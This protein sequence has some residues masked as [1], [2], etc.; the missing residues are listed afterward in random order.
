MNRHVRVALATLGVAAVAAIPQAHPAAAQ[1]GDPIAGAVE[2]FATTS[3]YPGVAVVVTDDDGTTH[4]TDYGVDADG[5]AISPTTPMPI[6]SA[7][8]TITAAAVM[9]LVAAGSVDLDSPVYDYLPDF[10]IHDPR[11]AEIT[12]RHLLEQTSGI[13][14]LTLREKSLAQPATLAEAEQR[15]RDA[16]LATDPG[17]KYAYT[18]TNFHLAAR[19]VEVVTG[20]PFGD[21]LRRNIFEPAGMD[22][23]T[24][25]D[26]TPEDLPSDVA[27][28]HVYAYG[29]TP[30]T[31]EPHRFVNGSDGVITTPEDLA[32]WLLVQQN[33]GVAPNGTRVLPAGTVAQVQTPRKGADYALGWEV[34]R[35]EDGKEVGHNGI[36]FTYTADI[37]LTSSGHGIVVI[38]N[39]GLGL[40]NEGTGEL[41]TRVAA[42]ADGET[43]D[44]MPPIRLWTD[45]VLAA[46]TLLSLGLGLRRLVR[47]RVWI[48]RFGDRRWWELTA[49]LVPRLV[50][51]LLLLALP[52]LVGQVVGGGRDISLLQLVYYSPALMIWAGL[53]AAANLATIV[54]RILGL[55]RRRGVALAESARPDKRPSRVGAS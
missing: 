47:T 38:G 7:S 50:P 53:A 26:V 24:T 11:G 4:H 17:E 1:T 21:H 52:S 33:D 48:D 5:S 10:R 54:A 31:A 19:L 16:E 40:G 28:G 30:S 6:A 12:V 8:K 32:T 15:A 25:I 36:W 44:P 35:T 3:G 2:D 18:N 46:L 49:R 22:R 34:D 9:Q 14:D 41:A 39:S 13:T 42:I 37:L 23:T 45:L 29:M 51:T 55:R 20:E 43:T 27:E